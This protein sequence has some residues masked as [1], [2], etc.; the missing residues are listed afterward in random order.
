ML[1]NETN[2]SLNSHLT[3][4]SG[5]AISGMHSFAAKNVYFTLVEKHSHTILRTTL[6]LTDKLNL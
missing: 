3:M 6:K 4:H 2:K 5:F 1:Q